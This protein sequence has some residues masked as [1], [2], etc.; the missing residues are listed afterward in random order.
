MRKCLEADSH[1]WLVA[2]A[3]EPNPENAKRGDHARYDSDPQPVLSV[4][5]R[6]KEAYERDHGANKRTPPVAA[7][8]LAHTPSSINRSLVFIVGQLLVGFIVQRID[9]SLASLDKGLT[10]A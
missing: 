4:V 2:T 7:T 3:R 8:S 5:R 10:L 1:P 6:D 9:V